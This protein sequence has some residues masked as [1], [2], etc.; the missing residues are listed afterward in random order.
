M[1]TKK[2]LLDH[3][4]DTHEVFHI[5][6]DGHFIEQVQD[7]ESIVNNCRVLA[8]K[9]PDKDFRHV[10]SIPA[11]VMDKAFREGWFHDEKAWKKWVN[12]PANSKFR[13]HG[14]RV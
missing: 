3:Y 9:P 2:I 13:V 4:A 8:D 1:T 10:A 12:D 6:P 11:W 7:C 14:G 5:T